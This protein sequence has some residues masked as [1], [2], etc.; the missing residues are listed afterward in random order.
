MTTSTGRPTADAGN[1]TRPGARNAGEPVAAGA[2]TGHGRSRAERRA[3]LGWRMQ[4]VRAA[5]WEA[6]ATGD[7]Y[8]RLLLGP[9]DDATEA[10]IVEAIGRRGAISRSVAGTL[11]VCDRSLSFD[12]LG[13][14]R[15]G[16]RG[17]DGAPSPLQVLELPGSGLDA[18]D[19]AG[20]PWPTPDR[21]TL[22]RLAGRVVTAW[23][24]SPPVAS[25]DAV[26]LV[27]TLAVDV[28][29]HI[30]GVDAGVLASVWPRLTPALDARL[31]PQRLDDAWDVLRATSHLRLILREAGTDPDAAP[32]RIGTLLV[33]ASTLERSLL[34]A[35]G[36]A[37]ASGASGASGAADT[38]GSAPAIRLHPRV[39]STDTI[40][41][42]LEV[43]AGDQVVVLDTGSDA[44]EDHSLLRAAGGPEAA[45]AGLLEAI[46]TALVDV[47]RDRS[48]RPVVHVDVFAQRSPVARRVVAASV[49]KGT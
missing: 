39:A 34:G 31:S 47:F 30:T 24:A 43:S 33:W 48:E 32:L 29:S 28:V 35:L 4:L 6:S 22:A 9:G 11:V 3:A 17:P 16:R 21:D 38:A 8:T 14:A 49:S 23:R 13:D 19:P 41:G 44:Q 37:G 36:A 40:L 18:D 45:A 10:A 5:I 26:A 42:G 46:P 12:V 1:R 7:D 15:F 2:A 25:R 20:E 27:R